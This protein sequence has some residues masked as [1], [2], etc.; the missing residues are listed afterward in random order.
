MGPNAADPGRPVVLVL[1]PTGRDGAASAE[2][3]CRATLAAR[4]CA[5]LPDLVRGLAAGADAVF[6]A[7]EA[8][9]NKPVDDLVA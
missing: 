5:S 1:A 4:P 9:F 8:L 6:V 3:L 2:M 7:E